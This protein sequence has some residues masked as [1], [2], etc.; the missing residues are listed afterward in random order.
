[1]IGRGL[2]SA[3]NKLIVSSD[4]MCVADDEMMSRI[5]LRLIQHSCENKYVKFYTFLNLKLLLLY[6]E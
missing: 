2:K 1:M 3:I 6:H 5:I 4:L